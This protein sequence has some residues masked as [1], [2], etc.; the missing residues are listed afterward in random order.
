LNS[1]IFIL[2]FEYFLCCMQG[3]QIFL[4]TTYQN[5]EKNNKWPWN[6]QIGHKNTNIFYCKTLLNLPKSGFRVWKYTI[7]Q[8]W[9]TV[10]LFLS[11]NHKN[12]VA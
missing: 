7:W 1:M 2:S 4:G 6:R 8:R 12:N 3:C 10:P 9:W 11:I 5:G